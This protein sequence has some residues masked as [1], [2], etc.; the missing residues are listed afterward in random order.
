[1]SQDDPDAPRHPPHRAYPQS[2]RPEIMTYEE[3][4]E[5]ALALGLWLEALA[6][7]AVEA[8]RSAGGDT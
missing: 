1:M 2:T 6:K 3:L 8:E 5:L 7:A 4:C